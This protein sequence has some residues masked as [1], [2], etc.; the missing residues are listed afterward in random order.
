MILASYAYMNDRTK[1]IIIYSIAVAELAKDQ[2][3]SEAFFLVNFSK[4]LTKC[5][6]NFALP[7]RKA[8][9]FVH[10]LEELKIGKK[11][12]LKLIDF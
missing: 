8:K 4:K 10:F 11:N 9:F 5:L 3:I 2:I 12:L 7:T 1:R 6:Q